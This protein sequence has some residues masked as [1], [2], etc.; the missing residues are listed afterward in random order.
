MLSTNVTKISPLTR[1]AKF[2][3]NLRKCCCAFVSTDRIQNAATLNHSSPDYII[4]VLHK[5][6]Q[7]FGGLIHARHSDWVSDAG[8]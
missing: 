6:L 8:K 4:M 1:S 5:F 2:S 3:T 7:Q